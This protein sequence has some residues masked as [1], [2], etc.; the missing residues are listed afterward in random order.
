[1]T[2][3][4]F[5]ELPFDEARTAL[6]ECCG[7]E[8]WAVEMTARRPYESIDQILEAAGLQWW[9]MGEY[10]WLEAFRAHSRSQ[11]TFQDQDTDS[12]DLSRISALQL[13]YYAT[14]GF[15]FVFYGDGRSRQDL[16]E[17][18]QS[19]V[20]NRPEIE[21]SNAAEAQTRITSA[22]L[23]SMLGTAT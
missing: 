18:L 4:H 6:L 2:L 19:R 15:N 21:I 23:V 1:M 10:G 3:D 12:E 20:E 9:R 7:S 13:E 5:N 11:A 22:R 14:F 16:L 17:E 8:A